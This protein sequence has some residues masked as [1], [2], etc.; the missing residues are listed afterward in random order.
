MWL[1]LQKQQTRLRRL[2]PKPSG[3][4]HRLSG[5]A[6]TRPAEKAPHTQG[7]RRQQQ[8]RPL[9]LALMHSQLPTQQG[10]LWQLLAQSLWQ[11]QPQ[12]LL[13]PPQMQQLQQL[14]PR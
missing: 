13:Q 4:R 12:Q 7:L 5:P 8:L 11:I 1:T 9:Q 2:Q 6:P 14:P 3:L 10:R